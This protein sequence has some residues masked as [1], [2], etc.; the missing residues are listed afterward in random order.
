MLIRILALQ[1]HVLL[2][3]QR[4]AKCINVFI[5]KAQYCKYIVQKY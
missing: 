5:K 4:Q 1:P 3:S 2:L